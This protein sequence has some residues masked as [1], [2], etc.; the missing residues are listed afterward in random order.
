MPFAMTLGRHQ[1]YHSVSTTRQQHGH[2]RK[3]Q[4]YQEGIP[5]VSLWRVNRQEDI[6]PVSSCFK[7][8]S[9]WSV[10]AMPVKNHFILNKTLSDFVPLVQNHGLRQ[11]FVHSLFG[12][13]ETVHLEDYNPHSLLEQLE[14]ELLLQ[15]SNKTPLLSSH[16]VLP[17][18]VIFHGTADRTVP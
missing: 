11:S 10:T 18:M 2:R 6:L 8:L 7:K 5:G 12:V 4:S 9:S 16:Q 13:S 17:H 1:Q 3:S 15:E 14:Q